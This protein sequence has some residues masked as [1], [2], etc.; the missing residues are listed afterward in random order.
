MKS[1]SPGQKDLRRALD[2]LGE[3]EK[4]VS[5]A[6]LNLSHNGVQELGDG[7][8]AAKVALSQMLGVAPEEQGDAILAETFR[9]MDP[10]KIALR[11]LTEI[12]EKGRPD[13]EDLKALVRICGRK[14]DRM[15]WDEFACEALQKVLNNRAAARQSLSVG[16]KP[17]R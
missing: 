11:V 4:I 12:A 13:S 16:A 1:G 2:L 8:S 15:G 6:G 3:V 9:S 10:M 17:S 7:L 14:P 5:S